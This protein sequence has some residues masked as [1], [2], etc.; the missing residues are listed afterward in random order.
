MKPTASREMP[1]KRMDARKRYTQ[2]IL[3]K[4]LLTL[5]QGKPINKITVKEVCDLAEL[6]RAT[7]YAHYKDCFHL[8]EHIENELIGTFAESLKLVTSFDV[9]ALIEAIY[10]LIEKNEEA[11]RVL[12]FHNPTSSVIHEMIQ[13]AREKS[14][15]YWK[16]ELKRA[17]DIDIDML[18]TH[19]SNGLMRIVVDGYDRYEKEDVIRFVNRIVQNSFSLF[20]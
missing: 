16:Q 12:I 11:C 4:S 15:R 5:L 1:T 19:L 13:L 14:I 2:M 8:L 6:N 17:S 18:Y 3:K 9:S 7:F 10:D 20:Q